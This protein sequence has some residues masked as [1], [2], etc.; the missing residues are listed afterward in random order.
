[1]HRRFTHGLLLVIFATILATAS[2]S[3]AW[4]QSA[5]NATM[6]QAANFRLAPGSPPPPGARR[7]FDEQFDGVLFRLRPGATPPAGA[8][9]LFADRYRLNSVGAGQIDKV[10]ELADVASDIEPNPVVSLGGTPSDPLAGQQYSLSKMGVP[11]AHDVTRG[12]GVKVAIVDSGVGCAHPDLSGQCLAGKSYVYGVPTPDD[13]QGHGTHVAGIVAA[14]CNGVG[15]TG[16][17]CQSQIIPVKVLAR[18]GSGDHGSIAAGVAWAADQ[19]AKVIN[20]SIGGTYGSDTLQEALRYALSKGS[21]PICAAGNSNSAAPSY[22]AAYPECVSVVATDQSDRRASFSNYG[23]T[24]D[25]AAPG[26]QV[27]STV[28]GDRYQAWDGTSMAAPNA[29][30]VAALIFAAHS[31]WSPDQVRAALEAGAD[32]LGAPGRDDQFGYGRLNA[33]GS[34]AGSAPAPAPL[35]TAISTPSDIDSASRLE[36]LINAYRAQNGPTAL[37]RTALPTDPRLRAAAAA[38]NEWMRRTGCFAHTCPGEPDPVE[39]ARQAGYPVAGTWGVGENIAAGYAHVDAVFQG[40]L[41]SPGHKAG[42]LT[43]VW[44]SNIGCAWTV[45]DGMTWASCEFGRASNLAPIPTSQPMPTRTPRSGDAGTA[46]PVSRPPMPTAQPMPTATP[47]A[48]APPPEYTMVIRFPYRWLSW[49]ETNWLYQTFCVG[50]RARGVTC[51]WV[52]D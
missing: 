41:N 15:V 29:A 9:H 22:P 17:A 30:G 8:V 16:V 52:K 51:Q 7:I 24:V 14:A 39:R 2:V 1:M 42:I 37:A 10:G 40:W 5:D 11:A 48:T 47:T 19:G 44:T 12:A 38:H 33:V 23:P 6:H 31:D 34:L 28:L 4:S 49:T 18:T 50:W 45:A 21:L 3:P 13:D 35:P 36:S 43:D 46:T 20:L 26:V 25:M 27:L 32:D